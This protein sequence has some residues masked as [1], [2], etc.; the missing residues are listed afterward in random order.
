[1][2]ENVEASS[3]K[4]AIVSLQLTQVNMSGPVRVDDSTLPAPWQAL[5][6]PA[7]NLRYYW[8]PSTN[9][10]TYQRPA[11]EP[12]AMPPASSYDDGY[13]VSFS[14]VAWLLP[15]VDLA[16]CI[17]ML[18][19][20]S[21]YNSNSSYGGGAG[22]Y[23]SGGGGGNGSAPGGS[24][25]S[26]PGVVREVHSKNS[27][28][29]LSPADY[30]RK[31]D[32]RY[33]GDNVPEALQTFESVGFPPDILDEIRRAGFPCP[34]PIQAAAWPVAMSGRDLVA[35]A[36]TGSGKTCGF[37]LPGMLHIKE[38]RKDPR[39]GPILLVLAPT[40]EL[41]VQTKSEADK[42][43]RSSGIRNTCLYG[44]APKGP[45]LRDISMGA[46]IAIAT[47]GRLNDFLEGGQV[48][49][50]NVSY[51]VLDEADRML[52]MG[53]EPQIQ[54]IVRTIPRQ[55]QTLFFSAT[56]PRE[57]KQIASQFV[58]N[59]TVHI[60]IGGVEE[61]LVA[62]KSITQ[63]V[64]VMGSNHEK[65]PELQR[66]LRSKPGG[67]RI[68]VFCTTK[69][70]CDQLSHSIS[71]DFRAAAIHVTQLLEQHTEAHR[72]GCEG[73]SLPSRVSCLYGGAPKGPQLRDISM[74]AHIAIATPG[75]LND[76][77][78]GGQVRLSNVS[79]LVLDEADRMLD[80]GFEPQIQ[81]IVRTI[82]RQRQTLFF[83]ATWPREVKQIASQFVTN[84]TV[85]IFIG[86][87]E[88]KLVAN[89][90][91]TQF[92]K[93]MG[94][95]HEKLPEL[96]RILRSKPG[97][98]RIIVFCT[99]KRMCDQLSHSI[100]RDFRA[101]AIHGDK[102]QQERDYVLAAFKSGQ[103]PV[104]IATDV[105]ARGLDIPHVA[106]V[107]NYDFPTGVEDYIH[108]IGRTGR[109]GATGESYTFLTFE[110]GKHARQ[111]A[112]VMSEA[113]Q[114]VSPELEQLA[115]S[116]RSFGACQPLLRQHLCTQQHLLQP[117]M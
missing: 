29:F 32:L 117:H 111:L 36:K 93:V 105:A 110:D 30:A 75:R 62:N 46:H 35:I 33:E 104:L 53:F 113:G 80:M 18:Q 87:V 115:G 116:S 7:S 9:V 90:S 114:V 92:V 28:G 27:T 5:H 31:H 4:T 58:T 37:L 84:Q 50:S 47:P 1:M 94:S 57:V 91:I 10:T 11:S 68:I 102:R 6:D 106:A 39:A 98:T 88:E 65:L 24:G 86:G 34:T 78:E 54:K 73:H 40:R 66:I 22:G 12:A 15:I 21:S 25:S 48:R 97:G 56:W 45:Q 44:G 72:P 14:Q 81:K 108:R 41:A 64:K 43:G 109:A 74:G 70:M 13:R 100:S 51:L 19:Q 55:R 96:Q 59:Q 101:A 79:Y 60:F 103:T 83:S 3:A 38:T 82:P 76:F 89:K 61:K 85:H 95:N 99:T 107:V 77:L 23:G 42:F 69:R 20:P 112:T 49:L 67:T 2:K 71:R 17:G 52:D 8:N 16:K 63:F 26:A